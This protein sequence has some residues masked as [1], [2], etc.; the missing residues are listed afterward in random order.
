[1]AQLIGGIELVSPIF[2]AFPG[3]IWRDNVEGIW[4][5]L[6]KRYEV[7]GSPSASTHIHIGLE[8]EYTLKDLKRIAQAVIHFEPAFEALLPECR[9]R[10]FQAKSNWLNAPGLARDG[11]SRLESIAVIEATLDFDELL[12]LLQPLKPSGDSYD[13]S[14]CWNFSNLHTKRSI[15]F[16]KKPVSTTPEE[17]LCWAELALSFVQASTCCESPEAFRRIPPTV[18]GLRWFLWKLADIP[19]VNQPERLER[20]WEGKNP[21]ATLQPELE[22]VTL[23]DRERPALEPR[24]RRQVTE[25]ENRVQMLIKRTQGRYW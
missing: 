3:S 8:P 22:Y 17:A 19:G 14:F 24:L 1:M 5:Y 21:E 6:W 25:E 13:K 15:E 10:N 11:K 18:G 2:Q 12:N 7:I 23:S 20:L 16:R 9:N 4:G